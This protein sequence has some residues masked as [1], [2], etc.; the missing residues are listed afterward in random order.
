MDL[1]KTVYIDE[2]GDPTLNEN[3]YV[4]CAVISNPADE[5]HDLQVVVQ[6]CKDMCGGSELKSSRTG[7]KLDQR[8]KICTRLSKLM[9]KCVVLIIRK[10]RLAKDGGF[11]FKPSSYKYCHRRLFEKIYREMNHVA[12]ILDTFGTKEFMRSFELP[13][14][15]RNLIAG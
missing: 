15:V 5:V 8:T 13:E 6:T 3:C 1:R 7:S 9:S 4:I 2:S 10:D 11:Q 12:V 14:S